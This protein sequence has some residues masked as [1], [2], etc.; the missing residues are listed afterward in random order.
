M[1]VLFKELFFSGAISLFMFEMISSAN[2]KNESSDCLCPNGLL[3]F[4][5]FNYYNYYCWNYDPAI[6]VS[7]SNAALSLSVLMVFLEIVF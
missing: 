5:S 7:F 4:D 1:N 6:F 3:I 2:P